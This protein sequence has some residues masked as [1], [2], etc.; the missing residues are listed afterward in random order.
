MHAL[1]VFDM[2]KDIQTPLV[3]CFLI[4]VA[5]RC[6]INCDYCYM[7][8]HLDQ[9]WKTQPALMSE[10]TLEAIVSRI[11]EYVVE[12]QLDHIAIVY[13]GGEP[14]LIGTEKLVSHSKLVRKLLPET[15]T[16]D[17]SLQT[18]GVLLNES[19]IIAFQENNIQ[20]SLS[21]DG[22]AKANDKHRLDHKGNSTYLD[23]ERALKLLEK[24]PKVFAGV[25]AVI[26]PSNSPT[27]LMNFFGNHSIPQLDFLLPDANYLTLPSGR[28]ENP[29]LYIDWLTECFDVWFDN[30]ST[31]KIR[32][33][34]NILGSLMGLPSETDAF[35]FGDVSLITIETDG[36]YH[37]LDVLKITGTGTNLSRGDVQTTSLNE[38]L[39]SEQVRKHQGLLRKEGLCEECQVCSVVDVCGGGA[40]A[41][42]FSQDGYNNP[43]IYCLEIKELIEHANISVTEQ[44]QTEIAQNQIQKQE[45]SESLIEEYETGMGITSSFLS[46]LKSFQENQLIHFLQVLK[47]LENNERL[48]NNIFLL[49]ELSKAELQHLAVQPSIVAWTEVHKK[50]MAGIVVHSIDGQPIPQDLSYIEQFLNLNSASTNHPHIHREDY[51]LRAPFGEKIYFEPYENAQK[52][53]YVLE[54]ALSL[55]DSWKPTLLK[56]IVLISPEIQYIRDLTAHPEKIVSFSDNSVPGAIYV[57]LWRESGLV[58][59]YD[60]ADSI[61]HEHRHQRLYLLQ[62]ICHIVHSDYPLV[63]SPWREELRPPTG[64]FHAL[65]VFVELLDFWSFLRD[66]PNSIVNERAK[67][68]CSAITQKI[69]KGFVTVESCDLTNNGRQLLNFLKQR[70]IALIA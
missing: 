37:D 65:Y 25:I 22:P 59:A 26:D 31:L 53:Q 52:G 33:F 14:L 35:G 29:N 39:T 51:W 70:F 45:I 60:L 4:K 7:Y 64:L 61:I 1:I 5:S 67:A 62:R 18:N 30:F 56:E 28:N 17:F 63:P 21:L 24:Y 9:S 11:R 50:N 49:F 68:E 13:H 10:K 54:E 15:V 40:V 6:N 20:V 19:D 2:H 58:D 42:R 41:H 48:K 69:H 66:K 47:S 38:A 44:L 23:C 55:I 36:S 16:V 12:K 34:D 43:S 3:R 46:T 8:N 57:Q 32:T 27:E